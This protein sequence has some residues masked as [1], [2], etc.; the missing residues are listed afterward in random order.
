MTERKKQDKKT[1]LAFSEAGYG[2]SFEKRFGQIV[3]M[4]GG[5]THAAEIC[6]VSRNTLYSWSKSDGKMPLSAA[7]KLAVEAHVTLDW[8]AVGWDRRPDLPKI[9]AAPVAPEEALDLAKIPVL[10][11]AAA[12]GP[13]V[14]NGEAMV[15]D[16]ILMPRA[17][18]RRIGVAPQN[19]HYIRV[20][21]DSMEPTIAD[22]AI[23]LIDARQRSFKA[24]AIYAISLDGDVRLKRLSRAL[25][26]AIMVLSDNPR[27][28]AE[29]LSATDAE[30]LKIEGR[31]VW[32]EHRL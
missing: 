16:H 13:G 18:L 2:M 11:V 31:V 12:A 3:A 27:Y 17:Q 30:A 21:G 28:P 8:V 19:A 20:L 9:E 6:G 5:A 24:E 32:T 10:S 14:A 4:A 15:E 26:G 23:V 22:G 29:R 7:L 25:D 1:Y